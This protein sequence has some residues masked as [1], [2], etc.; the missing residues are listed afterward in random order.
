MGML[1]GRVAVVTGAARGQGRAHAVALAAEGATVVLADIVDQ[2][3][4]VPYP[5]STRADLDEAVA[6]ICAAGGSAIAVETDVRSSESVRE[7]FDQVDA[8]FGRLDVLVANAGI[9]AFSEVDAISDEMWSDMI[10]TNLAGGFRCIRAAV[11]LMKRGGFGRIVAISSGAGRGGM[12]NLGHYS[13]SKWGLIGLVKTV[14]LEVATAGITANVVCPTTVATPMVLNES[15]FRIFC[16]ELEHPTLEDALPR[17]AGL[18]PMRVP[19]VEPE[20]V[21][22]AVMYFVGAAHTS[23]AVLE[24]DLGSSANRT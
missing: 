1:D 6:E 24:V 23:G 12:R 13:A 3:A 14:A 7:L 19:W 17:F 21:T 5:L 2:I 9:C 18:S 22:R 16:P 4:T 11:P 20:E 15:T 10:E 8:R